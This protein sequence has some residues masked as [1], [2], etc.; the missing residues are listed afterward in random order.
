MMFK[1]SK[2]YTAITDGDIARM[3]EVLAQGVD[4][5]HEDD[6]GRSFLW[7]AVNRG[8]LAAVQTL[9]EAG[10]AV[11]V[12]NKYNGT[13]LQVAARKGSVEIAS[14]LLE[15]N[16]KLLEQR[17][18]EGNT[19]LH[20]AAESGY[21]DLVAFLIEKG[22]DANAKNF[23]NRSPL[24]LAQKN[25]HHEVADL[26]KPYA[27]ARMRLVPALDPEAA[28]AAVAEAA[29]LSDAW[30]KLPGERI[31][32]VAVEEAIGYRITE[33]FNFSAR[34]KTTL[35]RNLESNAETVETRGFDAIG[36][37]APIEQAL[38]ELRKRGGVSEPSSVTGF[39][40]K[41]LTP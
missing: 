21:P 25:N 1:K 30:R 41:K 18:R 36:D 16:P 29:P 24:S 8:N 3:K 26:L 31:A 4:P 40:K 23:N 32:H 2:L 33:I 7:F 34:E 13:V 9:V 20:T 11:T 6:Y 28:P 5:D 39:E 14:Y 17:D 22:L 27:P 38:E 35:Y 15:K 10:A 12:A 37:K 19:A